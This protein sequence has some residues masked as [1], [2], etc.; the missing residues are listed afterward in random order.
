L[1]TDSAGFV[2]EDHGGQRF[3]HLVRNEVGDLKANC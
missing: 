1:V 3:T 2:V